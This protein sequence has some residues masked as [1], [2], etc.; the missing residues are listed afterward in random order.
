MTVSAFKIFFPTFS[1]TSRGATTIDHLMQSEFE[2]I[3]DEFAMISSTA[4]VLPKPKCLAL[5]KG[6]E[7]KAVFLALF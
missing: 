4:K 2:E 3:R 7:V 6:H 5:S 1:G